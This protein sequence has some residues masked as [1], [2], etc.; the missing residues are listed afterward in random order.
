MNN[1]SKTIFESI[2][3]VKNRP[4]LFL[5][6]IFSSLISSTWFVSFLAGYITL[7]QFTVFLPFMLFLSIFVT[8]IIASMVRD[9]KKGLYQGVRESLNNWKKTF[10]ITLIIMF[11]T[12]V[13]LTMPLIGVSFYIIYNSVLVL[14]FSL[15]VTLVF[16]IIFVFSSYFLPVAILEND[17]VRDIFSDSFRTSESNPREVSLLTMFSFVLLA[18]AVTSTGYLETLG[19][20]GFVLGRVMSSIVT[21]YVLV[22]SPKYYLEN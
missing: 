17:A 4:R 15:L 19:Y 18:V 7:S 20:I 13:A 5:P 2:E 21:T 10:Y 1:A 3:L 12:L 16:L 9:E 22:V 6:R 14:I 11:S 8:L